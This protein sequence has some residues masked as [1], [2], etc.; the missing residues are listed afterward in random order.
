MLLLLIV[1]IIYIKICLLSKF[2]AIYRLACGRRS[3]QQLK[4]NHGC[5]WLLLLVFLCQL[6]YSSISALGQVRYVDLFLRFFN[7]YFILC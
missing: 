7:F 3:L 2:V 4:R 1:Y 5:G 6:Y